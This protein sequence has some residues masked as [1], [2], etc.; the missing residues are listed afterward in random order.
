MLLVL[1]N[2]QADDGAHTQLDLRQVGAEL[3][4]AIGNL[5]PTMNEVR[6]ESYLACRLDDDG[7]PY[8]WAPWTPDGQQPHVVA[9]GPLAEL[10]E[11]NADQVGGNVG[12][13]VAYLRT[14]PSDW[15]VALD[16]S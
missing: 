9:A 12:A 5:S 14:R 3:G 15:G 2:N 10:L 6:L 7:V 13:A 1:D 8:P 11:R 16:W 4:E